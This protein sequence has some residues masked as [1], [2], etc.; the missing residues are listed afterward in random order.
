M[1]E[2]PWTSTYRGEIIDANGKEIIY[3]TPDTARLIVR[4]VN[5]FEPL[6]E[7]AKAALCVM[8]DETIQKLRAA[9]ALAG[10]GK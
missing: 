5:S 10:E 9:I 4:A 1:S 7:A 8:T 3:T 2:R 6:V